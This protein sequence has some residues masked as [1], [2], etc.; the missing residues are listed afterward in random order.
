MK[1]TIAVQ[2]WVD[3]IQQWRQAAV[4]LPDGV[5]IQRIR[6]DAMQDNREVLSLFDVDF[7]RGSLPR[8]PR[9]AESEAPTEDRIALAL[10]RIAGCFERLEKLET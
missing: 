2:A 8:A 4:D 1:L 7:V 6:G 3:G 10:E 5:F 9:E